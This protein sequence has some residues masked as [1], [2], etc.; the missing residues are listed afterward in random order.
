MQDVALKKTIDLSWGC[1]EAYTVVCKQLGLPLVPLEGRV[2]KPSLDFRQST[3]IGS[4]Q[5]G[6]VFPRRVSR[7]TR[8]EGSD[9]TLVPWET[10]APISR[11]RKNM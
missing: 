10:D 11:R 3:L 4:D 9:C 5:D 7:C 1:L 8:R 2:P 6:R